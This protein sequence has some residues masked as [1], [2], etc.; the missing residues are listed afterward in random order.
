MIFAIVPN[1]TESSGLRLFTSYSAMEQAIRKTPKC[2]G[3]GYDGV[4]ELVPVW[5]YTLE[6][7]GML[8]RQYVT[9]LPLRS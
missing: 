2:F 5:I 6:D 3:V 4:D 7:S 1:D 8:T 9:S